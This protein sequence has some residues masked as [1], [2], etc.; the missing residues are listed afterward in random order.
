MDNKDE[1]DRSG[2][3]NELTFNYRGVGLGVG[4]YI[5]PQYL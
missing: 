3:E 1:N 5:S 4:G 2:G